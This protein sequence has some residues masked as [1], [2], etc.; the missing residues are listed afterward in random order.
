VRDS[1]QKYFL[2]IPFFSLPKERRKVKLCFLS[3]SKNDKIDSCGG[4]VGGGGLGG[5][6]IKEI[7]LIYDC[8]LMK[9]AQTLHLS[10]LKQTKQLFPFRL[11]L[12]HGQNVLQQRKNEGVGGWTEEGKACARLTKS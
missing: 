6:K 1:L 11:K 9:N 8:K 10:K 12:L 4:E 3:L 7:V 5:L 2:E